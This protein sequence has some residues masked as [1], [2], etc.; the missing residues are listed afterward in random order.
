MFEKQLFNNILPAMKVER[1]GIISEELMKYFPVKESQEKAAIIVNDIFGGLNIEQIGR[2]RDLQNFLRSVILAPDWMETNFKNIPT[3]MFLKGKVGKQYR[4]IM[5][6]VIMAY[7]TAN[8]TNKTLSG[9]WMWEND[10]GHQ[11]QIKIIKNYS[12]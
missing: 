6:N 10:P 8:V 5:K 4:S 3:G 2:S 12:S 1:W 9:H 11:F 7:I